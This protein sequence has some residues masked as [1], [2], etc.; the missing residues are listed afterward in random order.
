[1]RLFPHALAGLS[2]LLLGCQSTP[3]PTA[4]PTPETHFAELRLT[5]DC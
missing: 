5:L 1:M 3:T 4:D 2:L